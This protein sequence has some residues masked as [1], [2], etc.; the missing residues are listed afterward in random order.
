M[1]SSQ[2]VAHTILVRQPMVIF[3]GETEY[4][5]EWSCSLE[6]EAKKALD[7]N[8][9]K[10]NT[11]T[12]LTGFYYQDDKPDQNPIDLWLSEIEKTDIIQDPH[13]EAYVKCNKPELKKLL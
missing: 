9:N 5:N 12:V 1:N 7:G 8:C 11:S 6:E 4:S 10:P 2:S 3:P 13:P